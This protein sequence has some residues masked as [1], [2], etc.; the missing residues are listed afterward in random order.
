MYSLNQSG[1]VIVQSL[2]AG[3]TSVGSGGGFYLSASSGPPSPLL[4][5]NTVVNNSGAES[6]VYLTGFDA[7]VQLFNNIVAAASTLPAVLFDT[8]YSSTPPVFDHSDLFNSAGPAA[9]GSCAAVVGTAGNISADPKFSGASDYHLQSS[10]PAIDAGNNSA[11]SLPATD[12]DGKPR[13]SGAA[14]DQGVYEFQPPLVLTMNAISGA[15][16]G[17]GFSAVLAHDSGGPGPYSAHI[18]C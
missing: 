5:N 13:I 4:V 6:G 17:A 12:L 8:T 3:N 9:S 7:Q 2:I 10:S 18:P 14:V 11:P 16:E 15:V 1:A